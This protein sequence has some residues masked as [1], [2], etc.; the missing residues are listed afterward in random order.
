V[1]AFSEGRTKHRGFDG[2]SIHENKLLGACLPAHARLPNQAADPD[3]QW[4][5]LRLFDS[6]KTIH[7]L[8][9]VEITDAIDQTRRG[10]QLKD[11]PLI[12]HEYER[13]FR[14]PRG[15]EVKLVLNVAALRV[16]RA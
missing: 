4:I 9:A 16:F 1:I 8:L 14:M 10:R 11:N 15:L 2:P 6:E 13:D 3:S 7:E 12:A 5:A